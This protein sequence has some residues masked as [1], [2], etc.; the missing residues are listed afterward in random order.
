LID[1]EFKKA[2]ERGGFFDCCYCDNILDVVRGMSMNNELKTIDMEQTLFITDLDGTLMRNDKSI[3]EESLS[4]ING[5]IKQGMTFTVATARSVS[6]LQHIV[7]PLDIQVPLVVRNGTALAAPG[8]LDI[9][10]KALFTDDEIGRLREL[11][12]ELPICGFTSIWNGNEMKKVFFDGE[13]SLGI[14]KYLEERPGEKGII[15]VGG[16]DEMFAGDVGYITMIDDKEKL[17]PIYERVK[18]LKGWETVLQK[19]S[20]ADEY[21]LELC[22]ENS[23]KAKAIVKLKEKLG[24]KKLVVFGDS[25]NDIP[26]FQ[27]A[28]AAYAVENAL[29]ELKKYATGIIASNE[30]DGVAHFLRDVIQ[31]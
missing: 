21:W 7:E 17:D 19:D 25:V 5:L 8:T 26:M 16:V 31:V 9:I 22:P 11:L 14:Q 27:I 10:E 1:A 4:I 24:K 23:T 28:D 20:Y 6:S 3:S 2:A 29:P 13:H 12:T 18:K 30:E 15:L